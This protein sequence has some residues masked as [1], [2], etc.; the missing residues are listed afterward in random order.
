MVKKTIAFF[1]FLFFSSFVFSQPHDDVPRAAIGKIKGT[2]LD[3]KSKI[4]VEFSTIA[5]FRKKDS[6]LVTGT[7][8]DSKGAFEIPSLEFG[9]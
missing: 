8:A 2:V 6:V 7:V 4:P 9:R 3:N 5:L 1:L